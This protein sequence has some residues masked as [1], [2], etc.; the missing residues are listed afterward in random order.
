MFKDLGGNVYPT[1]LNFAVEKYI[2]RVERLL[3]GR[4]PTYDSKL[5]NS[6]QFDCYVFHPALGL[7]FVALSPVG[8]PLEYAVSF[9]DLKKVDGNTPATDLV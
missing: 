5:F 3:S 9:L 8:I 2:G 1:R 6:S 4:H 7:F